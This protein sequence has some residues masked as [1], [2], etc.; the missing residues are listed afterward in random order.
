MPKYLTEA[1]GKGA[2][3]EKVLVEGTCVS[4]AMKMHGLWWP[5]PEWYVLTNFLWAL[6]GGGKDRTGLSGCYDWI[7]KHSTEQ[8]PHE[9]P[10]QAEVAQLLEDPVVRGK[11][12][13][14]PVEKAHVRQAPV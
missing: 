7:S 12:F 1:W 8:T 4:L 13:L 2:Y 11:S 9:T 3:K 10:P 14:N 6:S 5:L